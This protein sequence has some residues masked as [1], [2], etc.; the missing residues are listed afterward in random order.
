MGKR[1]TPWFNMINSPARVGYY[2]A[3]GMLLK[4]AFFDG[5]HWRP[6][7]RDSLI[8]VS[9]FKWRGLAHKGDK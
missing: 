6:D 4:S 7:E 8:I 9:P 2:E 3:K 5:Y 1:Y